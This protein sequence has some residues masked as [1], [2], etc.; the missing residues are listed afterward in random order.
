MCEDG[1]SLGS[2]GQFCDCAAAAA[3]AAAVR[4]T[5]THTHNHKTHRD[6]VGLPVD[7]THARTGRRGACRENCQGSLPTQHSCHLQE[8]QQGGGGGRERARDT[9]ETQHVATAKSATEHRRKR[10]GGGL[11]PETERGRESRRE[12]D[13]KREG[14][15]EGRHSR[16][17]PCQR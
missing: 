3:A 9:T 11:T 15:G 12:W 13:E 14:E 7:G 2:A 5:Y 17:F 4:L 1:T 10:W 16:V 6:V 8:L